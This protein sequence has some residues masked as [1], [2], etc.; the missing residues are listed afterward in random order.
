MWQRAGISVIIAHVMILTMN[1]I[2]LCLNCNPDHMFGFE[3][4]QQSSDH[5]LEIY[6]SQLTHRDRISENNR[7][8]NNK[9]IIKPRTNHIRIGSY[10][11]RRKYFTETQLR[12]PNYDLPKASKNIKRSNATANTP[13]TNGGNTSARAKAKGKIQ[14]TNTTNFV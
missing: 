9:I 7:K 1:S 10:P 13:V 5:M 12:S 3:K 8:L 11:R 2:P 4:Y 6:K 14:N